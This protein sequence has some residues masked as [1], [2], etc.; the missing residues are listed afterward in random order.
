MSRRVK[1]TVVYPLDPLGPK[2]G[3]SVTFV[4]GLLQHAPPTIELRFVGVTCD[5]V[6]RPLMRWTT[7]HMEGRRFEFL[8]V[9][10]EAREDQRHHVP[11]SLRFV[12]A[13]A[14][15]GLADDGALLVHNRLETLLG[16]GVRKHR[17]IAFVHN[18]VPAQV[19]SGPSEVL[20]SRF[21]W[22]YY[23]F[24]QHALKYVDQ[25]YT[26]S[27][28]TLRDY[29]RRHPAAQ[30]KF[31]FVPTWVDPSRFAPSVEPKRAVR[32]RLVAR[33]LDIA[34]DAPWIL[35]VGRL[36]P[37]KAPQRLLDAFALLRQQQPQAQ[38]ILIGDGNLRGA[39]EDKVRRQG[40][41][42]SVRLLGPVPQTELPAYYHAADLL[43]LTSDFEGM[44]MCVLEALACGLPV[45][46]T[47]VGEVARVV[48]SGTTG[49]IAEAADASSVCSALLRAL[50]RARDV[51]TGYDPRAC[52]A[53]VRPFSPPQVL[54]PIYA[55][56]DELTRCDDAPT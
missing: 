35:Y 4:R 3:G 45:V 19:G 32:A 55:R 41:A 28:N 52:A 25:V 29:R 50:G 54:A 6:Q 20:W 38:L 9:L 34:I 33:G 53:V 56:I 2:V 47:R 5:L 36:Q 27:T 16:R 39:V 10:H 26:V 1:V 24:E 23:R 7:Q 15:A 46:T 14:G 13:L 21:P 18:D 44:P 37:Q 43:V 31:A 49:E 22:L 42:A 51:R 17:N 11:L 8:A 30:E 48:H 40:L 12:L